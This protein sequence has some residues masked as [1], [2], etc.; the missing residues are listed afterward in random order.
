MGTLIKKVE[1]NSAMKKIVEENALGFASVDK[2]GYP[3]NIAVA[4]VKLIEGNKLLISNNY[5]QETVDN[6]KNNPNVA[7]V[8][9]ID[10]WKE[11]CIG[12]EFMGR[13]EYFTSGKWLE[14][15]KKIPENKEA[16]CKGAILVTVNKIKVLD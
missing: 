8:A 2:N 13:A 7:L 10:G 1:I 6:I 9:W 5:L 11:N 12:Y 14:E 3:H 4:F 16:P 15:I